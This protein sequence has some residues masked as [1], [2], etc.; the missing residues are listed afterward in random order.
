[1]IVHDKKM[2]IF[3]SSKINDGQ[4]FSA[5]GTKKLPESK[6]NSGIKDFLQRKSIKYRHIYRVQQIHSNKI[7]EV[8]FS[9]VSNIE[10]GDGLITDDKNIVLA[11]KTADCVPIIFA[12]KKDGLIG[13]SHQGWKG[14]YARLAQKMIQ[15]F[16]ERGSSKK[17]ILVAIGPSIGQCCYEVQ[18]DVFS[19]FK[20]E[21]PLYKDI[22][23]QV[24]NKKSINLIKCNYL[25][26]LEV[27]I[28]KEN[29]EFFPF[30]TCC[31]EDIFF[32]YRRDYYLNY[33]RFGQQI[34]FIFK[35]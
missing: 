24:E 34:S 15:K 18:D 27:G 4:F 3:Y 20:Q 19:K 32:S 8:T 21:F 17:D 30:C 11:I 23:S 12:D 29:I 26:L 2:G 13:I 7:I 31:D 16:I 28:A 6:D 10:E 22:G 33:D 25:Q 35:Q 14:T 5:F 9:N 1:M